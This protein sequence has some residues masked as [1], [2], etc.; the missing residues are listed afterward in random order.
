M[1]EHNHSSPQI[2]SL[3]VLFYHNCEP[4]AET[5]SLLHPQEKGRSGPAA[6]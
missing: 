1:I 4:D 5:I 3:L 6:I 2:R